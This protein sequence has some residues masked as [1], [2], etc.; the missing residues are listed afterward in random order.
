MCAQAANQCF[1]SH[2]AAVTGPP[3]NAEGWQDL[4]AQASAVSVSK[5][6]VQTSGT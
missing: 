4:V 5:L 6:V 1:D 3:G 2:Q